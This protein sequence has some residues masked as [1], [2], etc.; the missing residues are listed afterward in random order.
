MQTRHKILIGITILF[1]LIIGGG[2][3][4][5]LQYT[6]PAIFMIVD[7]ITQDISGSRFIMD[8]V[9]VGELEKS[10]SDKVTGAV[11]RVRFNQKVNIPSNSEFLMTIDQDSRIVIDVK[12]NASA[13]YIKAGDTI[14]DLQLSEYLPEGLFAV[15]EAGTNSGQS[16]ESASIESTPE[17]RVQLIASKVKLDPGSVKFRAIN[18]INEFKED[19]WYKYYIGPYYNFDEAKT[20]REQMVKAGFKDAFIV[21]YRDNKR[22]SI[23]D[24][25][26]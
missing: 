4:V 6:K 21:A 11:Y 1:M 26:Q 5:Y 20:S 12:L 23:K 25:L 22:I 17:F 8:G 16:N 24:A 10:Q 18:G 3:L 7:G 15:D 14:T 9:K 2:Y 19:G 13:D